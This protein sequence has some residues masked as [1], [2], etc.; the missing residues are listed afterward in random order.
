MLHSVITSYSIHYTKLY[1]EELAVGV[2]RLVGHA[3]H[4][5]G[6]L[7]WIYIVGEWDSGSSGLRADM[8]KGSP[9]G[10]AAGGHGPIMGPCRNRNNFV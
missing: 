8:Q 7:T 2:A 4:H 1:D 5:G 3:V 9:D 10:C 6:R